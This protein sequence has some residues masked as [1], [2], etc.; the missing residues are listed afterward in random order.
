MIEYEARIEVGERIPPAAKSWGRYVTVAAETFSDGV[1]QVEAL[2][3]TGE[4][5][6]SMETINQ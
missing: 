2:L 6:F 3:K 4:V 1:A 5:V